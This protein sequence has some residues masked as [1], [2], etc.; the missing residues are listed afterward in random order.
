MT[1]TRF[2]IMCVAAFQWSFFGYSIK[3]KDRLNAYGSACLGI[4]FSIW[5]TFG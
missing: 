2:L 3:S 5:A 1:I 4:L